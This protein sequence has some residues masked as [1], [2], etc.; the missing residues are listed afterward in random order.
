MK[1]EAQRIAIAGVCGWQR[2]QRPLS[3]QDGEIPGKFEIRWFHPKVH[4][5]VYPLY[6]LPKNPPDYLTDLNAMH[7]AY[8]GHRDSLSVSVEKVNFEERFLI[9]LQGVCLGGD[10]PQSLGMCRWILF[11]PWHTANATASQRAEAFLRTL[12]KWEEDK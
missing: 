11:A 6:A 2:M 1:P 4:T 7:E 8:H 3:D 9:E 10:S 5:S 12:G